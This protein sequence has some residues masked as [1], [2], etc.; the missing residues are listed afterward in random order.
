MGSSFEKKKLK[1]LRSNEILLN[2]Y[3]MFHLLKN[4]N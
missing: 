4:L 2:I 1:L 3:F